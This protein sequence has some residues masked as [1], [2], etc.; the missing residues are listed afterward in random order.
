[1]APTSDKLR[2]VKLRIMDKMA[3]KNYGH[4]DYNFQVCVG[5]PSKKRSAYKVSTHLLSLPPS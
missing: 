4:Y 2:E 3:C 5:S 1:M